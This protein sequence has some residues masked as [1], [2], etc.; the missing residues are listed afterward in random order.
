MSDEMKE[1]PKGAE[2][3]KQSAEVELNETDLSDVTGGLNP[4]P[5][6]PGIQ[7]IDHDPE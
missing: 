1:A 5:L 6:P 2:P 3:K 4:Q 7:I